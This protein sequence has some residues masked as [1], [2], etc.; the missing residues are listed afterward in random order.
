MLFNGKLCD[1]VHGD[2]AIAGDKTIVLWKSI[3][4][5]I[6]PNVRHFRTTNI[7]HI[8]G[9]SSKYRQLKTRLAPTEKQW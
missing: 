7:V 6:T 1:F 5:Q 3:R 9:N 4:Q 8:K 2:Q